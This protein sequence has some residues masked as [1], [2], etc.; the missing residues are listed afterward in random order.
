MQNLGIAELHKNPA[1][2]NHLD[3]VAAII[4]KKNKDIK[5]YFFPIC[6]KEDIEEILKEIEYRQ[7]L[8]R[9]Q[10]LISKS[11]KEDETLMDGLEDAY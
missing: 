4:N 3:D 9:N 1:I 11:T 5:G 2:L 7:F 10:S 6:F 8:K